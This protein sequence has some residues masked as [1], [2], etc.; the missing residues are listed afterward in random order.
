MK[1]G[2]CEFLKPKITAIVLGLLLVAFTAGTL[3]VGIN[4][5][6]NNSSG[7]VVTSTAFNINPTNWLNLTPGGSGTQTLSTANGGSLT[8]TWNTYGTWYTTYDDG[9]AGDNQVYHGW[10]EFDPWWNSAPTPGQYYFTISGLNSAFPSGCVVQTVAGDDGC[11]TFQP[12][13]VTNGSQTLNYSAFLPYTDSALGGVSTVST[14][15]TD[16]TITLI[17]PQGAWTAPG[18]Y[19]QAGTLSGVI[20]RDPPQ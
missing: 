16:D 3:P 15:I 4:L 14:V 11:S 10:A 8:M 17:V 18:G 9:V 1:I 19:L 2:K 7:D 12:T 13:T 5:Q 6:D 20:L